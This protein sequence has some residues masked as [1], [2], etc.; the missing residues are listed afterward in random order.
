[1][2]TPPFNISARPD[3]TVKVPV[4]RCTGYPSSSEMF[5]ST[6]G[7]EPGSGTGSTLERDLAVVGGDQLDE[8]P[9]GR[10]R[11]PLPRPRLEVRHVVEP[12]PDPA[13]LDQPAVAEDPCP[14]VPGQ[15]DRR[16]MRSRGVDDV[17]YTHLDLLDHQVRG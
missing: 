13:S 17:R 1:M 7:P 11:D 16:G 6:A 15:V 9:A 3:L 8:R 5:E 10:E 14:S 12:R 4:S 2:I